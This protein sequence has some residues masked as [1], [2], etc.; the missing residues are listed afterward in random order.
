MFGPNDSDELRKKVT[1][2]EAFINPMKRL[3]QLEEV[4]KTIIH[5]SHVH[6]YKVTGQILQVDGGLHLTS[7]GLREWRG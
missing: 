5:L 7:R 1:Q 6:A 4:C 3:A 2:Q